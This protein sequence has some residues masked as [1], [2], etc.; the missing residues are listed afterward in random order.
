MD[1]KKPPASTW[2]VCTTSVS[3]GLPAWWANRSRTRP[4]EVLTLTMFLADR[5]VHAGE[6]PAE[7]GAGAV[8]APEGDGV[9]L[10]VGARLPA[11]DRVRRGGQEAERIVPD[12]DM[13]A[14][15]DPG[16]LADGVHPPAAF[17]QLP[18]LLG[19]PAGPGRELGCAAG[20]RR[21][22]RSRR[23]CRCAGHG[24]GNGSRHGKREHARGDAGKRPGDLPAMKH[25]TP[26]LNG[27]YRGILHVESAEQRQGRQADEREFATLRHAVSGSARIALG[28]CRVCLA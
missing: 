26:V 25:G 24:G 1:L 27:L 28:Y 21:P 22:D 16:E 3:T 2:C 23:C 17:H 11:R 5:S 4:V 8:A 20:G 13:A 10:A 19:V 6:G 15:P 12:V 7:V 9:D 18:D 14:L